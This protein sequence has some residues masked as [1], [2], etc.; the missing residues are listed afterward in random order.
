MKSGVRVLLVED[1]PTDAELISREIR[2]VFVESIFLRVETRQD[3][4]A[5]LTDFNPDIILCDFKL[6]QFDG[7]SALALAQEIVPDIPFIIVTGSMNEDTAV[8]C[9]KA[10]A[11]D[12][13][14]KERLRRLG[15]AAANVMK[16]RDIRLE[17][18]AAREK[19]DRWEKIFTMAQFGLA[20]SDVGS[21]ILFEVNPTYAQ[22]RGYTVEELQG[23]SS[24]DIFAP[25]VRDK[26]QS[27]LN[28]ADHKG[29][30]VFES[31]HLRKDGSRFPVLLEVTTLF[32]DMGH[33]RSRIC[34]AMDISLLKEAQKHEIESMHR[35]RILVDQSRDGIVVLDE[36]G[37]VV[38]NNKRFAQMLGYNQNEVLRLTVTDWEFQYSREETFGMIQA[39]DESGMFFETRHRRK[40]GSV[41]DV[42]ISTNAAQIDGRK[43]VFCICRDISQRKQAEEALRASEE[44]LRKAQSLLLATQRM[45]KLG[46]W[47]YDVER[48]RLTWTDE[49]YRIHELSKDFDCNDPKTNFSFYAPE[50]Q[51]RIFRAFFNCVEKGVPYDLELKLVGARGTRKWVRTAAQAERR[52]NKIIRVY[53]NIMD[54]TEA[55]YIHA[56]R[57]LLATAI[58]QVGE[59]L[60]ITDP[61]GIIRYT[62]PAFESVTGFSRDETLGQTPRLLKSGKHDL[63]FYQNLWQTINK[64]KIWS[65][66]LINKRKNGELYSEDCTIT[67]VIDATGQIINYVA[68]KRDISETLR[69]ESQFQQA[70]KMESVG[71]LAGGVAHDYNN[72]L[73]VVIG[74]SELAL[75][76]IRQDDPLYGDLH[77]ILKAAER[78]R[79]ITRQLLAFARKQTITPEVLD[80]NAAIEGML[81]IL[82]RLIGEDIDLAWMPGGNLWP[83]KIDPS[84]VDQILANLCVNARDAISGVGR[85]TI[86]TENIALG[87]Q[88]CL[89]IPGAEAGDYLLLTVRDDGS[90]MSSETLENIFEPFFTTKEVGKGTGLGLATVYGIVK[91]N[92]GFIDVE[93]EVG[94]G[95]VFKLYFPRHYTPADS[96][97]SKDQTAPVKGNNELILLVEDDE[98]V[99]M[100]AHR[101]LLHL[102]YQVLVADSPGNALDLASEHGDDIQ[103]LLTDV[104]MPEMNGREL[105][106]RLQASN[107]KLKVLFMSGYSADVIAHRGV[108]DKG[109]NFIHKPFST[110]DM[111]IALRRVLDKPATDFSGR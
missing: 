15:P 28:E 27:Y 10:G 59:V 12:Y 34:F 78:S 106:E 41:F 103:L 90:G 53:G 92:N 6:P 26:A 77:Q 95:T 61:D 57:D 93:S 87:E 42:E 99:L 66:R 51:K 110:L 70:Q 109:V 79:D 18:K 69:L 105:V 63:T 102:G 91:Q 17:K 100:L 74:Y 23:W 80:L 67:P 40:D 101:M 84:Q 33:P 1:L 64:G 38:E 98:G 20:Y 4:L 36:N 49:V 37:D 2:G 65:G 86:K 11:W 44:A 50:D 56:E 104:V 47:E 46:G 43:Q 72:I 83:L 58:A 62:N 52:D 24:L 111:S 19:S 30:I 16:Q 96:I 108:L 29:H 5:A 32:D 3:F 85:L 94:K 68:V 75:Q 60:I 39:V 9:M 31:T 21:G 89:H 71:R 25:E 88:D 14:I 54:I 73:S 45:A 76:Q 107:P 35:R 97:A 13:V 48:Q 81:R 7:L 55:K 22:E 8:E 82:R